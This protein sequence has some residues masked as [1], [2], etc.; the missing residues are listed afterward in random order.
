MNIASYGY[1]KLCSYVRSY[2]LEKYN[3]VDTHKH[4][5]KLLVAS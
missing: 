2:A 3:D 4:Q 5:T 1:S